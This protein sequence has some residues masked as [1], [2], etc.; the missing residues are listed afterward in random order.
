MT[1]ELEKTEKIEI[2]RLIRDGL[3]AN[4]AMGQKALEDF[5]MGKPRDLYATQNILVSKMLI[6]KIRKFCA[7]EINPEAFDKYSESL[8]IIIKDMSDIV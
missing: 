8:A 2:C 3:T 6:P 7:P 5:L 1:I 4:V